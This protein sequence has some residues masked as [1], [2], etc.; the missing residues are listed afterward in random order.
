MNDQSVALL[1]EHQHR[2]L[3]TRLALLDRQLYEAE[4]FVRGDLGSGPMFET[5]SDLKT[6]ETEALLDLFAAAR[7]SLTKLRDRFALTVHGEE[8][9][10]WLLGHFSILWNILQ[11]S[12]AEKLKGFGEVARDLGPQL[13]P[14]IDHLI[15]IVSRVRTLISS[16]SVSAS[17][18]A[19]ETTNACQK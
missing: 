6:E 4:R 19:D 14:E 8:V 9:R 11:D 2:A 15:E 3:S 7:E 5:R 12:H 17:H 10:H 13:D 18:H 1:N 16:S